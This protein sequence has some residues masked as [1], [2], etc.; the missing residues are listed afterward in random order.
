VGGP[1]LFIGLYAVGNVLFFPGSVLTIAA[2]F[3][4]GLWWGTAFVWCGAM[5]GA[6]LAFVLGRNVFRF[7]GSWATNQS[8]RI[9]MLERVF[10]K[11]GWKFILLL[12]I[13]PIMPY[14]ALNYALSLV[15]GI[16]LRDYALSTALGMIPGVF[17]FVYIGTLAKTLAD[18]VSGKQTV[19]SS[20]L[21]GVFL[22]VGA[23]V[24]VL[25]VGIMTWLA[26]REIRRETA[27]A[28]SSNGSI[29][30]RSQ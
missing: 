26:A 30:S 29:Q 27:S 2:G 17:L 11:N 14:N 6:N 25:S 12:R 24:T 22:G 20:P 19:M 7:C 18:V 23:G 4:W 9:A 15:D 3:I 8:A 10:S 13:S 5:V 28:S 16:R 21:Q 1:A